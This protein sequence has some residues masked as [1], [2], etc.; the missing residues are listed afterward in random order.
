MHYVDV[1]TRKLFP[2]YWLF[3]KR[4]GGFCHK[5]P[6]V[7]CFD[8]FVVNLK[9]ILNRQWNNR[10]F[11]TPWGSR[12]VTTML[13]AVLS[14]TPDRNP[15]ILRPSQPGELFK[16]VISWYI[17]SY[18]IMY[19]VTCVMPGY[20]MKSCWTI[21]VNESLWATIRTTKSWYFA[22]E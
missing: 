10:W 4:G 14:S 22:V 7:Q 3:L 12:D 11:E 13:S 2:F 17:S 18:S 1:M 16:V 8:V 19:S 21:L 20:N 5:G 6:P 15:P 9:K